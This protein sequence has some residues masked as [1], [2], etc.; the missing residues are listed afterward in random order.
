MCTVHAES[1]ELVPARFQENINAASQT[2]PDAE[3]FMRR[4]VDLV[5]H[6]KRDPKGQR[7]IS[8]IYEMKNDLYMLR[9][10]QPVSA[11]AA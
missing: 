1:A 7:F 3:T 10:R 4:L 2:L 8:D 11:E 6:I 9:D 5:I